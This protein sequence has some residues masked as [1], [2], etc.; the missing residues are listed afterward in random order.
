MVIIRGGCSC[1][2][3]SGGGSGRKSGGKCGSC[4]NFFTGG[5]GAINS[6][7][8]YYNGNNVVPYGT[9][10]PLNTYLLDPQLMIKGGKTHRFNRRNKRFRRTKRNRINEKSLKKRRGSRRI[11]GGASMLQDVT[12]V[13]T[14]AGSYINNTALLAQGQT[15]NYPSSPTIQPMANHYPIRPWTT[16]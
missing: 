2:K 15:P 8:Q 1:N 10:Y 11:R 4:G 6:T 3:F 13:F 14:G 16:Y 9:S 5:G 12:N 7:V